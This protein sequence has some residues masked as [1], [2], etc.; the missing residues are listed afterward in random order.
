MFMTDSVFSRK[1]LEMVT[2]N[3]ARL[4]QR[5]QLGKIRRIFGR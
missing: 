5:D 4:K 2:I 1:T 3:P